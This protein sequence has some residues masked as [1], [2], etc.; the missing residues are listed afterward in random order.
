ML[1]QGSVGQY[2]QVQ[3]NG[4]NDALPRICRGSHASA[5]QYGKVQNNGGNDALPRVCRSVQ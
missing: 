2:D 4:G 3:D 1:L 5:G